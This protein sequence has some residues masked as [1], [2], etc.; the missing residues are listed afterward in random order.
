MKS[1]LLAIAII[2]GMVSLFVPA[3][4]IAI[5]KE[6]RWRSIHDKSRSN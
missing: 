3:V 5:I 6:H 2:M 1:L 4:I